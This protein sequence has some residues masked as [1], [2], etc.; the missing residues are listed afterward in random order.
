MIA[1]DE[2]L[3]VEGYKIERFVALGLGR[4]D[5]I[6]A[7]EAGIDWHTVEQLVNEKGC[8]LVVA[9]EIAR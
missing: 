5:A 9:L 8:P 7:V 2:I 3:R 4:Y 6:K 1:G